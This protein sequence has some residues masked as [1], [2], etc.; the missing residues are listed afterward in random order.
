LLEASAEM[1]LKSA[2]ADKI[3][4]GFSLSFEAALP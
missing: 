1:M 3:R 4:E 2:Q